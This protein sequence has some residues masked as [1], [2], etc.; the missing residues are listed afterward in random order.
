MKLRLQ[1]K[2]LDVCQARGGAGP[3]VAAALINALP[4]PDNANYSMAR[5]ISEGVAGVSFAG[6]PHS[7]PNYHISLD[8]L[9]LEASRRR[10]GTSNVPDITLDSG[11]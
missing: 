10:Y 11:N 6:A 9:G 4:S 5:Q 2:L 1:L 3:S 8:Q 7:T